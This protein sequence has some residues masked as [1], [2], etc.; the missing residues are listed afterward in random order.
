MNLALTLHPPYSLQPIPLKALLKTQ[1]SISVGPTYNASLE[2]HVIVHKMLFH[3]Y[4]VSDDLSQI[5]QIQ[6]WL[7]TQN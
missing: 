1:R 7:L 4:S 2:L 5:T 6:C 3:L